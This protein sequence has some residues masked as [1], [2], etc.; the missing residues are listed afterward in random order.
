MKYISGSLPKWLYNFTF[1][2][3][4]QLSRNQCYLVANEKTLNLNLLKLTGD[5]CKDPKV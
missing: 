2:H 1:R 5:Y 4:L 3:K